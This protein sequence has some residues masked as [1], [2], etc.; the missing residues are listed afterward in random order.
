M[1]PREGDA[2]KALRRTYITSALVCGRNRK[3]V[4]G[5]LGHTTSRMVVEVYDSFLD[6]MNWPDP[7]ERRRLARFYG[8]ADVP[9]LRHPGCASLRNEEA[10]RGNP[11]SGLGELARPA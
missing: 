8:W 4:A 10:R 6:P 2:Q 1:S 11:A 9:P 7:L 5:E 3:L